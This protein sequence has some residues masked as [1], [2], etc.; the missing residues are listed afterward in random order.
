VDRTTILRAFF[1]R[2]VLFGL[3][4]SCLI[5]MRAIDQF[6]VDLCS[7]PYMMVTNI[8]LLVLWDL[9]RRHDLPA[10]R[11]VK[12][13]ILDHI[14]INQGRSGVVRWT[15]IISSTGW[16]EESSSELLTIGSD[17][18]LLLPVLVAF[19]AGPT[20][21]AISRNCRLSLI[22][23]ILVPTVDSSTSRWSS[24][25]LLIHLI[26]GSSIWNAHL[27]SVGLV[28]EK[29][30]LLLNRTCTLIVWYTLLWYI[31]LAFLSQNKLLI[32]QVWCGS[33]CSVQMSWSR[34]LSIMEPIVLHV[35]LNFL[36]FARRAN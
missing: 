11:S 29:L 2:H 5:L 4:S 36:C 31:T 22:L 30:T 16:M 6:H 10:G 35:D 8:N 23:T 28:L 19:G 14:V 33:I 34:G 27:A 25:W 32:L 20:S 7:S 26:C 13:M 24:C 21:V 15:L 18:S 3:D 12:L 9:F 1:S 17:S